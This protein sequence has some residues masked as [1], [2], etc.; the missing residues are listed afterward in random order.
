M[1]WQMRERRGEEAP[2]TLGVK[3]GD[4]AVTDGDQATERPG[5]VGGLP[6]R[7][8]LTLSPSHDKL[9]FQEVGLSGCH[10]EMWE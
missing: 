10:L 7:S 9:L 6:L 2:S 1:V 3:A 8:A 5:W 4:S